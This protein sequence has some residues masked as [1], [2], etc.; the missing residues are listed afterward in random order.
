MLLIYIIYLIYKLKTKKIKKNRLNRYIKLVLKKEVIILFMISSIISNTYLNYLNSKYEKFYKSIPDDI[1]AK[2]IIVSEKKKKEYSNIYVVK[3]IEGKYNGK[4]FY[5]STKK[6]TKLEYGSLVKINGKYIKPNS[7]RN[8][9]GFNYKEY[10]KTKKIYGTIKQKDSI[11]V[12]E[13]NKLNPIYIISNN[14]RQSIKNKCNKILPEETSNLLIGILIG[15]KSE[16]SEEIIE[17]FKTSNLSHM[18]AV[19]GI[20]TSYIILGTTYLLNK[21]KM[22]KK[23]IYIFT[24]FIL[25]LFMFITNFTPSVTRACTSSIIILFSNLLYRKSDVIT[26]LSIP[27]LITLII[28]PFLIN[29]IG[30]QLSYLGTI[31]IILFNKNVENILI[32]LHI[33]SKI[34]KLLSIPISAQIAIMPIMMLKFNTISFTFFISNILA[35]P[36][37][38]I[39]IILGFI[40]I[41]VYLISFKLAKLFAIPLNLIL[42]GLIIISTNCAKIPLSKII[43]KTP[44]L[45]SIVVFYLSYLFLNY[46][47]SIYNS[48][49]NL[50][51][52]EKKIIR[53]LNKINIRK[54]IYILTI[55]VILINTIYDFYNLIPKDLKIYF[56]DVSQGDS[57]L[58]VTPKNKKI[59]IDGGEKS[60]EVLLSYLLD[61]RITKIDYI[62]ISH[63]DS[64]HCNGLI[65]VIKNLKVKNILISKQAYFCDEYKNIANIINSK[66]INVTYLKQGDILNI[67]KNIKL[68]VYYPKEELEY[69]DLNNNSLVT[70]IEY[71]KFS[72]LFTG[73]IEKSEKDILEKYKQNIKSDILKVAHHGS[74]TSSSEEFLK[75]VNPKIA[76]I[77]VG[78]NNKFN[79]PNDE[80]IERLENIKCKI[81]RTDLMGEIEIRVNKNKKI[82]IN[83]KVK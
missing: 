19:S 38:G 9:K 29:E 24:I 44:N 46:I 63:F 67:E 54:L 50:R 15:D 47:Y 61:R 78:E 34:S 10:L 12:I 25:L 55:L 40:T 60:P 73:D 18:L 77:G 69:D 26:G 30:L 11:K 8:Y 64:D 49:Y 5:L 23:W 59:L 31:G 7:A 74:K 62:I 35:S 13:E 33:N 58:I 14:I 81:Y 39:S 1:E 28:N 80:V 2:G 36:F 32:K 82:K 68:N 72:I 4:K 75:A 66:K 42:R 20:H 21:S 16:I 3:I 56:I 45:I 27:L 48:K 53:F 52:F 65:D 79:H 17:N 51:L 83:T 6:N 43:V 41:V 22:P 57:C 37:L 76:L 71:N 70:K